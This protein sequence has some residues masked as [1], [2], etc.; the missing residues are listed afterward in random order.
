VAAN[1]NVVSAAQITCRLDL[2][3]TVPGPWDVIVI[4]PDGRSST[5]PNGFTVSSE[6]HHLSFNTIDNQTVSVPFTVTITAHDRYN[7]VVSDFTGPASL[8]D[9]TGTLNPTIT[10][11]FA[12]GVWTGALTIS[13]AQAGV[14]INA[15]Y[16]SHSGISNNFDVAYPAPQV[17]SIL[18]STG[19]NTGTVS[20]TITGSSFFA[21]P[22]ARLGVKHL[23]S[24][25]FVTGT[26]LTAIVP[27]G[28]AAGTYDLYV[29]NPGP[30]NP[31]GV[32]TD[33]FKVQN[34]VIPSTTLESSFL[35]TYG[36][37]PTSVTN[38]DNDSV[39]VI[40]LEVPNTLTETLYVRIYDAD[41]GGGLTETIDAAYP[42]FSN[43]WDTATNFSLYGGN[44][45]HANPNA[46]QATFASTTDP[47]ITSGTLLASQTFTQNAAMDRTWF[48]LATIA[49][50]QGENVGGKY[51][52]KLSVVGGA[53]NDGNLYN[54][55]LSTSDSDNVI[56]QGAR[57]F[58][59]SWTFRLPNVE[60]LQL[61]P[62]VAS[63]S[64]LNQYN[65][66][67][68]NTATIRI[69]TPITVHVV[70][71]ISGEGTWV[72]S[73]YPATSD[74]QQVT[75]AVRFRDTGAGNDGAA[76]FT[77]QGGTPLPIFT[78]STTESVPS[79]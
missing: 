40:F 28:I 27:A 9:T 5:L 47:G 71:D 72:T 74:E 8:S 26:T 36:I 66:D 76:W 35:T 41:V 63:S 34:A 59:Y 77:D 54:V 24:V 12:V 69:T 67:L 18:P 49:P 65:F 62:Y 11:N 32:L 1:V 16:D 23:Q 51:V 64:T 73:S 78:R 43:D 70:T 42:F 45:T 2:A 7:N 4:N 29:T 22:S 68:D 52:F 19:V 3:G 33:A 37:S 60:S 13:Q 50:N 10:G 46:R 75:W 44:G 39:Q 38:G 48:T 14:T 15:T 6:L 21:T 61:Y 20:V 58:A 79:P 17:T 55:A 57:T 53:G 31:T 30:L 25:T 56:P